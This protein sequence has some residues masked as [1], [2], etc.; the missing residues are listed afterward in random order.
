MSGVHAPAGMIYNLRLLPECGVVMLKKIV[1]L[2][3]FL[4]CG[5][6]FADEASVKKLVEAKLGNKVQSVTKTPYGGLYEVYVDKNLHYTDEKVSF[7][8]YGVLVDT[9]TNL[10]VTEQRMRKLTALNMAQL[11]PLNMAIKRVKGN[12][13]RE[14]RV[15]S[16]PQC[17]FCRKL[18]AQLDR[19]NNV[20]IYIYPFPLETKFPGSTN[21]AKSIWCS[22]DKAKAWEDWTLRALRPTGRTDCAN[23]IE[24][25]DAVATKLNIDTTP[26]LVFADGGVLKQYVSAEDIERFLN[27]MSAK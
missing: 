13:K 5:A 9:K 23:P 20:T 16:D 8:L 2:F 6:A 7:I 27:D 14:L 1:L 11:P 15:F 12:G 24:Q 18:E 26:T 21:L 25:I 19:I 10:N 3:A 17:P 4:M 22:S